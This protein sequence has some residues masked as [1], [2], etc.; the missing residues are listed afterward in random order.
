MGLTISLVVHWVQ[1]LVSALGSVFSLG[2]QLLEQCEYTSLYIG[3]KELLTWRRCQSRLSCFHHFKLSKKEFFDVCIYM[4][5][6]V[7]YVLGAV[8][9]FLNAVPSAGI[10]RGIS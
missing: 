5:L 10:F 7:R 2:M 4:C 6:L 3:M 9:T 8:E 1:K